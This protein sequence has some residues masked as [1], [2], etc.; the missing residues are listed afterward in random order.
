MKRGIKIRSRLLIGALVLVGLIAVQLLVVLPQQLNELGLKG[1]QDRAA[2][3]SALTAGAVLAGL[4][5]EDENALNSALKPLSQAPDVRYALV[6][7]LDGDIVAKHPEGETSTPERVTPNAAGSIRF[8]MSEDLLHSGQTVMALD[9]PIGTLQIGL[10]LQELKNARKAN[11]QSALEITALLVVVV[12][13]GILLLG[14]ALTRPILL[15]TRTADAVARGNLENIE[16][17]KRIGRADS[18]DELERLSHSFFFMLERILSSQRE[19]QAQITEATKERSRAEA[20]LA[21]LETTQEQLIKSEKLASLGQLIAGIAHEINTPLGAIT[22]SSEI[23]ATRLEDSFRGN[24]ALYESL[25]QE[26]QQLVFSLLELASHGVRAQGRDGRRLRKQLAELLSEKNMEPAREIAEMMLELG[27]QN[28]TAPWE[29][30]LAR[31]D[32]SSILTIATALSPLMR[33]ASNVSLAAVKAKRIVMALKTFSRTSDDTIRAPIDIGRNIQTVLT[34]YE[35]Q[36]KHGMVVE[37]TLPPD[38]TIYGNGD[39]ISQVWT[40]LIQNAIQAMKGHGRIW[41]EAIESVGEIKVTLSNDGPAI[42]EDVASRIFE[43]F[44]TTKPTGEG[45]GLGLD[46]VKRIVT[47]HDGQI[48]VE[49]NEEQTTFHVLLG[50]G[51]P[52]PTNESD[53]SPGVN[54]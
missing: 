49:S 1:A 6:F 5:F 14:F 44:F 8:L 24:T 12:L 35:N 10:S 41:I 28:P 54:G 31:S 53:D 48:W 38:M 43:A 33:N 42:P 39:E 17:N 13:I 19:I 52:G 9:G 27:Y 25:D 36:M 21:H 3:V 26:G 46:I 20:A 51:A 40:N 32:A 23:I 2:A 11:Q 15:L 4:A 22:A 45:T 50:K 37:T 16:F 34:L 30:L 47:S 7:N 29:E 18:A